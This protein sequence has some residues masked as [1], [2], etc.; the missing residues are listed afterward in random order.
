MRHLVGAVAVITTEGSGALHGFTATAVCSVTADP[1][2]ILIAVNKTAR[3]HPHIDKK[4]FYTVN[5]MAED[6]MKTAHHF[7]TKGDD[8]FKDVG[9][10]LSKNGVPLLD[11]A[12]AYLECQVQDRIEIG[13]H[14]LFVGRVIGTGVSNKKPLV[15][16]DGKYG[17]VQHM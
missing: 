5:L 11:G 8:Q 4:G 9:Y 14:T 10:T 1:P 12:T 17:S 2:T 7:S 13:T 3:T 6:Q 15:Y 16:H